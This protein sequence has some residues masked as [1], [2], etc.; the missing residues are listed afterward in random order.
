MFGTRESSA[1]EYQVRVGELTFL[2]EA[3]SIRTIRWHGVEVVRGIA[4]PIR[5]RDWGTLFQENVDQTIK[6]SPDGFQSS[7]T[8]TVADGALSCDLK[9]AASP[10]GRLSAALSMTANCDFQTNRAG[11]TILHP[12]AG[13][14]G[15]PL[16]LRHSDGGVEDTEFP[17]F[18]RPDQ[19]AMDL[20]GM[21]HNVGGVS[22]DLAFSGEIFEMEDQRNWTDAS[23]KTYCRPLE[24]PFTYTIAAGET[25]TQGIELTVS[26]SPKASANAAA[27]GPLTIGPGDRVFPDIG[28]AIEPEWLA[29]ST[30]DRALKLCGAR[31]LQVRLNTVADDRYLSAAGKLAGELD[32]TVDAEIV[33]PSGADLD[34]ALSAV[35]AN[36]EKAGLVPERIIALPEDY[37][38]SYQPSGPWPDGATPQDAALAARR[39][40]PDVAIGGGVLTNF[41]EFNRCRPEPDVVDYITHGTTAIVHAADD[42]SVIETLEALPQVFASALELSGDK[43]Y[44]LGLVS[45]GMRSNPY[46][47]AVAANPDRV[48]KTMAMED[49]RQRGLFAAAW[50]VGAVAAAAGGPV[51]ALSLAAPAGPFAILNI[52]Q[53]NVGPPFDEPNVTLLPLYQVVRFAASLSG[54]DTCRI[55]GL[56]D[57]VHG[58]AAHQGGRTAMA[59]ANL[60]QT[61]ASVQLRSGRL[62]VRLLD[63]E[64]FDQAIRDENWL[65]NAPMGSASMVTLPPLAV[66]FVSLAEDCS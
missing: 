11:F 55:S 7:L 31:F 66:A 33:V 4:W 17:K 38:A 23:Y 42:R 53:T 59:L 49:P 28:L 44:R 51:D 6:E 25:V 52:G 41:T 47:A 27:E 36:M 64:S 32:V 19:P 43:P 2:L 60:G 20:V 45:I 12:I 35:A 30:G 5:D 21:A 56:S 29:V 65:E 16:R 40:F 62:A 13:V 8:F 9:I 24:F 63:A 57:G 34:G 58:F 10:A 39:A 48:R 18:V 3:E 1:P 15:S 14:A 50:A 37:L 61:Q 22:V 26:G 54:A 46:G